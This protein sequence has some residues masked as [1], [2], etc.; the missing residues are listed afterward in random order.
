MSR[1][2]K[3]WSEVSG[4]LSKVLGPRERESNRSGRVP[5]YDLFHPKYEEIC[6]QREENGKREKTKGYDTG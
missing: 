4:L 2:A 6:K 3:H 5:V 1:R